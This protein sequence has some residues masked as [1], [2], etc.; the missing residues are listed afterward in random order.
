MIKKKRSPKIFFGWWSVL[1]TCVI[2]GLSAALCHSGISVFFKPLAAELGINRAEASIA[3]GV[4]R[5]E[6]GIGAQLAGWLCDKFGPRWVIV[7]GACIV[8]IGLVMMNFINSLWTFVLVWGG[9]IGIG[10]NIGFTLAI[11]KNIANWFV[12]KRGLALG[13]RFVLMGTGAVVVLPTAAWLVSTQGWRMTNLIFAGAVFAGIPLLWLFVKQNR[14]EYYG[15]LPDGAAVEEEAADTSEMIEKGVKYA[16]ESEEVEFTLRQ[17][18]KTRS[19][20]ML[21]VAWCTG[22]LVMGG[23][24]IHVIPFLTDL[25]I[26]PLMAAGMMAMVQFFTIPSRFVGS[27]LADHFR[28][29]RLQFLLAATFL[30]QSLGLAAIALK[31]NLTMIYVFLILK[32]LGGGAST[33]LRVIIG[34]RYFGRKAFGTILGSILMVEAPIGFLAPIYTGW[35]YDTTGNYITAFATFAAL[36]GIATFLMFLVRPPKPPDEVTDINKFM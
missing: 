33:P 17:A 24:G 23:I 30:L 35:I 20:W 16:A 5:L 26:D 18:M 3:T 31:Q 25:G 34:S 7:A 12:R 32:G 27:L 15:L 11:D 13:I 36:S 14:P 9:I 4:G 1:V 28:K 6:G 10:T 8:G 22:M 2:A 21:L 19:Y 29:D